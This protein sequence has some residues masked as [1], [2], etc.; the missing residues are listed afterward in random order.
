MARMSESWQQ[1]IRGLHEVVVETG[2]ELSHGSI[3]LRESGTPA[4]TNVAGA[5]TRLSTGDRVE[6]R[7]GAGVVLRHGTAGAPIRGRT[8]GGGRLAQHA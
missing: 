5:A 1:V 7:A 8:R 3:L 4:V 2:G 6:V